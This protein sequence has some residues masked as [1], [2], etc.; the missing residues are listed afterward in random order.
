MTKMMRMTTLLTKTPPSVGV[1]RNTATPKK[2][3]RVIS[4]MPYLGSERNQQKTSRSTN[5]FEKCRGYFSRRP[6]E[7]WCRS[8]RRARTVRATAASLSAS[9][10]GWPLQ[11]FLSGSTKDIC[12]SIT[13]VTRNLPGRASLTRTEMIPIG[14]RRT[15]RQEGA[16]FLFWPAIQPKKYFRTGEANFSRRISTIALTPI[17][18]S[19]RW[20]SIWP[21]ATTVVLRPRRREDQGPTAMRPTGSKLH[22]WGPGLKWAWLV[23]PA[24]SGR[25]LTVFLQMKHHH[26]Q[27]NLTLYF[28]ILTRSSWTDPSVDTTSSSWR[29]AL[30]C[31]PYRRC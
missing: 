6:E 1:T 25:Q 16:P 14:D 3:P 18:S 31:C 11:K 30:V 7:A 8:E 12:R 19:R 22:S 2:L 9:R 27:K 26:L 29:L 15:P 13:R 4:P 23:L 21:L 10:S 17:K 20:T 24:S 5:L 28:L